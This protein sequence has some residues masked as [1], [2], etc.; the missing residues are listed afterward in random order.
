[1]LATGAAAKEALD[2]FAALSAPFGVTVDVRDGLGV[3]RL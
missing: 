1:M 3:V 2:E